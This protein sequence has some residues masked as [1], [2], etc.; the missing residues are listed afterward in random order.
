MCVADSAG[1]RSAIAVMTFT[2]GAWACS[3]SE[4]PAPAVAPD[5]GAA[6]V[7]HDTAPPPDTAP[8]VEVPYPAPHPPMPQVRSLG[9]KVLATPKVVVVT[10]DGEPYRGELEAFPTALGKSTYWAAVVGEYGVGPITAASSRPVHL[11]EPAPA[12]IDDADLKKWL[13]DKLDGTHPEWDPPDG[14]TIYQIYFPERTI[15]TL[16]TGW[17][18][19]KEF[20]ASDNALVRK[21]GSIVP[22][23]ATPRC[24]NVG[25]LDA[26]NTLTMITSHELLEE[27]TDPFKDAWVTMRDQDM[28]WSFTPPFSEIGDMCTTDP[29][30]IIVPDDL[31]FAV[32]RAWSNA[33]A[34]A[35]KNPCVPAAPTA[36]YYNTLPVLTEDVPMAFASFDWS[37]MTKGVTVHV[38]E[39]KTIDLALFS[40]RKTDAWKIEVYDWAALEGRPAELAVHLDDP[41]GKNGDVRKLTITALHAGADGGSRFAIFSKLNHDY[42]FAVGYVAN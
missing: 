3:A 42:T 24:A 5:G 2:A 9:G 4:A 8:A 21:D 26:I 16:G 17:T 33:A 19:C 22:Y 27:A 32:Q 25:G 15:Y 13:E 31:G 7:M 12:T 11:S 34:A 40:D 14:Q 37:A 30:A 38:G 23:V 39:S 1:V 28:A 29:G 35:G 41:S 6:V 36:P 20:L 10:Y 18:G